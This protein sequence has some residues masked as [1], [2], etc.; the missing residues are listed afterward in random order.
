MIPAD[1]LE[2]ALALAEEKD[3]GESK[4]RE[5]LLRGEELADVYERYGIL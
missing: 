2:E 5:A 4:V 1:L 3:K